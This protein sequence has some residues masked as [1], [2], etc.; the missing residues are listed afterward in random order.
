MGITITTQRPD[1]QAIM[2]HYGITSSYPRA[3]VIR[4]ISQALRRRSG[5]AWSVTGGRGTAYGWLTISAPPSRRLHPGGSCMNDIDCAELGRL[6]GLGR[7][8]FCQGEGIAAS[9]DYRAEYLQR[10][11]GDPVTIS[12]KQYWD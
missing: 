11:H 4:A 8:A 10:A 7:P 2:A 9:Y 5:R 12:G 3:E 6:L 1:P